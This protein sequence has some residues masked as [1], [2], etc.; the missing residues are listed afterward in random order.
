MKK[1]NIEGILIDHE[2]RST[3]QR[4]AVL[5]VFID[6]KK[7]MSLSDLNKFLGK[8]FD[9]ITLYRTLNSFEEK[10]LIHKIADKES[11]SYAICNH[12]AIAHTHDE[13]HIHFKCNNCKMV[14]CLESIAIPEVKIPRKFKVENHNYIVEGLCDKCA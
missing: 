11:P 3:P 1:K 14:Q 10:G 5:K 9:R 6:K 4:T 8:E 13:N 12:E 7:A 2:L